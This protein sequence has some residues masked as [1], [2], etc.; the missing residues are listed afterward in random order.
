MTLAAR[1]PTAT[2]APGV[3]Q[4]LV[5]RHIS[6]DFYEHLLAEIGDRP[7]RVTYS[8]GSM[9]IMAPLPK[10]EA[11]KKVIAQLIE[12]MTLE[13]AIPRACFGSTTFRREDK[14]SG[15]E[16]DECYYIQNAARVRGMER[17]D[18]NLHPVPDLAIEVDITRRSVPRQP[19]YA[20]L[21]I[22]EL[23]RFDGKELQI[24]HLT[25]QGYVPS[26]RSLAFPFLPMDRFESFVHRMLAG[27]DDLP[28]LQDFRAWVR[29]LR[30]A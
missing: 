18:P 24:L 20:S 26:T 10:H 13:L 4:H 25:P 11:A 2:D 30:P 19:V 12:L 3:E 22:P 23:W 14:E 28:V 16:P 1:P 5:L 6:W 17:F 15:L 9:E 29:T 7:L 27:H 8:Q 21:G